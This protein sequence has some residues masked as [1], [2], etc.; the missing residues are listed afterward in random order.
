MKTALLSSLILSTGAGCYYLFK[1][2]RKPT[3]GNTIYKIGA[4]PLQFL[5]TPNKHFLTKFPK[6]IGIIG[7]GSAGLAMARRL[8]LEGYAFDI[9]DA[10]SSYGGVW[11][12][13]YDG[14]KLQFPYIHYNIPDFPLPNDSSELTTLPELK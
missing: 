7:A 1:D 13:N 5:D 8:K 6:T 2:R 11:H 14:A 10:K 12:E 9:I 4:K 3:S